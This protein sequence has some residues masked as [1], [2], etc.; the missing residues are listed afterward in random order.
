MKDLSK[1]EITG[2]SEPVYTKLTALD[3][4]MDK[5]M[6]NVKGIPVQLG[7]LMT[8]KKATKKQAISLAQRPR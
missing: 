8:F 5:Q 3:N 4:W 1:I 2:E 7:E 6:F